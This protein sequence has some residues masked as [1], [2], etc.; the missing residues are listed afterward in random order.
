MHVYYEDI[1]L[2]VPEKP[3]WWSNGYPRYG[4]FHPSMVDVYASRVALIHTK[5]ICGTDYFQ[6]VVVK[7]EEIFRNR[8]MVGEIGMGDPPNACDF[9]GDS[10]CSNAST[11]CREIRILE[12][13]AKDRTGREWV[14]HPELE[15]ELTDHFE[16]EP[17]WRPVDLTESELSVVQ[18]AFDQGGK[19]AAAATVIRIAKVDIA[20]AKFWVD[21]H[22]WKSGWTLLG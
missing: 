11:C 8:V 18:A 15:L 17:K 10:A 7:N 2:R 12:Y 19:P 20:S 4:K 22:F 14:R 21:N 13:W 9:L 16:S 3:T 6:A 5:C 1:L